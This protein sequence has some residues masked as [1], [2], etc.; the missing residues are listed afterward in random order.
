MILDK[1]FRRI[2]FLMENERYNQALNI[3]YAARASDPET[4]I[5]AALIATCL[6]DTDRLDDALNEIER[7]IGLEPENAFYHYER[8]RILFLADKNQKALEVIKNAL[9]LDPE[10]A[11]YHA[12]QGQIFLDLKQWDNARRASLRALELDPENEA[13]HPCLAFSL[14]QLGQDEVAA[15][16]M[17]EALKHNPESPY[18]MASQ[19]NILTYQRKYEEA[20]T[21]FREALK[22]DPHCE[23]ARY[24]II[25]VL[26]AKNPFYRVLLKFNVWISKFS[27][28][29]IIAAI[30]IAWFLTRILRN[31][32]KHYP[33]LEP[34][35][36]PIL[37]VYLLVV[38]YL[39]FCDPISQFLLRLNR[40]G[41]YYLTPIE[42]RGA[43]FTGIW[44]GLS[45][46]CGIA[47]FLLS[48]QVFIYLTFGFLLLI[49][50]F[51][52]AYD[53]SQD[54]PKLYLT[55]AWVMA[56]MVFLWF[57]L[58]LLQSP[59]RSVALGAF[60]IGL[61]IFQW[62]TAILQAKR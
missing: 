25:E 34:Y 38:A 40:N 48:N 16:A 18:T 14:Q 35:V 5:Y 2:Q 58:V 43:N 54:K 53:E 22:L 19:G 11:S 46:L 9:E 41:K 55:F 7:S 20:A 1:D 13:A 31:L 50:P 23:A 3:L 27:G 30:F 33:T 15:Q 39:W 21:F 37:T 57:G 28:N 61:I 59:L 42:R 49:L 52:Q 51:H 24:G 17:L 10:D 44:L 45:V 6:A 12:L 4:A 8:A 26:K 60:V 56:A 47:G 36:A 29:M 62:G 32:S